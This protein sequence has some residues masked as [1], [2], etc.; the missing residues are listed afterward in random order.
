ME[1]RKLKITELEKVLTG[2]LEQLLEKGFSE[3]SYGQRWV[4]DI[5]LRN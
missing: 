5:N 3:S 1:L 4:V 2:V